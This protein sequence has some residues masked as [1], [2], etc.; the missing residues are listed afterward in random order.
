MPTAVSNDLFDVF[1]VVVFFFSFLW[2]LLFLFVLTFAVYDLRL[3]ISPLFMVG[4]I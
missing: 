1:F 4:S 2:L 3:L